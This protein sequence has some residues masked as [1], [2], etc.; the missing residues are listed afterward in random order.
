[1][2][3]QGGSG[4]SLPTL[5]GFLHEHFRTVAPPPPTAVPVVSLGFTWQLKRHGSATSGAR[6]STATAVWPRLPRT[7]EIWQRPSS[8]TATP[9]GLLAIADALVGV[10]RGLEADADRVHLRGTPIA[11]NKCGSA[12]KPYRLNVAHPSVQR[13]S[14]H[15]SHPD[16]ADPEAVADLVE[17]L[18]YKGLERPPLEFAEL[19]QRQSRRVVPSPHTVAGYLP[20]R[21]GPTSSLGSDPVATTGRGGREKA[22][23]ILRPAFT[24]P[25]SCSKCLNNRRSRGESG[26]ADR[27]AALA[28]GAPHAEAATPGAV[29]AKVGTHAVALPQG[30]N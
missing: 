18:V 29:V 14:V 6:S 15:V 5:G 7:T 30:G 8:A 26:R 11:H 27:S 13:L 22:H 3:C 2:R 12:R 25:L 28:F 24:Q 21:S 20:A 4:F 16:P 10:A 19:T 1:M 23:Q 9:C 17:E